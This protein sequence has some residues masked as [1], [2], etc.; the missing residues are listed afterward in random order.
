MGLSKGATRALL[1]VF[2]GP[3]AFLTH[4]RNAGQKEKAKE[5]RSKLKEEQARAAAQ[6]RTLRLQKNAGASGSARGVGGSGTLL[7]GAGGPNDPALTGKQTL[8]GSG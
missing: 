5:K 7:A 8:L 6:E 4:H 1:G 2:V 3:E